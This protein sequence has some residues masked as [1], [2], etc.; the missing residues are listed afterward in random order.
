MSTTC[1]RDPETL[2]LERSRPHVVPAARV[3]RPS[4][5]GMAVIA[6]ALAISVSPAGADN[7]MYRGGSGLSGAYSE[8]I[9]LPLALDWRYTTAFAP[10][11]TSSP[12][13]VGKTVY[14]AGG[15][16]VY[17][18]SSDSGAL[19]WQFPVDQPLSTLIAS[20]PAV[21]DNVVYCGALDGKLY[22]LNAD[23]GK[24][25]WAFDTRS[26]IGSSPTVQDGVIYFGSGD[27]RVWAIDAKTGESSAGPWK[28]G[29]KTSDEITGAPAIANGFVYA[30]SLD[31]VIHAIGS[32]TG[33][34]RWSQRLPGSVLNKS[35]VAFGDY[36]YV[37]DGPN[38]HCIAGRTGVTKWVQLLNSDIAVTPAV[39]DEGLFLVTNDNHV[40]SFDSRTG[41]PRWKTEP[42][43]DF[44]AV[45][46]PMVSGTTLVVG[47]TEGGVYAIDTTSGAIKWTYHLMPASNNTE[48]IGEASNIAAAPVISDGTVYVISN[49]GLA[50]F[51]SD[52]V[53]TLGPLITDTE[54]DMGIV[55]NGA[56][57]IHME[58]KVTD[59]GS[60]V[61]PDSV[62]ILLDGVGVPKRPE[63]RDNEDKP[64][65]KYDVREGIVEYDTPAPTGASTVVP[66]ADGRHT[67]TITASDWMG[68]TASKSWSFTVDNTIARRYIRKRDVRA[69]QSRGSGQ[70]GPGGYPG[71][72]GRGSGSGGPGGGRGRGGGSGG[73]GA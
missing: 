12:A 27:G 71:G 56:P 13:V 25:M 8:K 64:G 43:L 31:Q 34:E 42:K 4:L 58:G 60:G 66:L 61:N 19:K 57:P 11:N 49:D 65:Y 40:R 44:D 21:V 23:S 37:A 38:I 35:P 59:E 70:G 30:L 54:P 50:A 20:S 28:G 39:S 69:S 6:L 51:R 36:V 14:F 73:G 45:A 22:A 47:T 7:T 17:A 9:T 62:R 55:I 63:G 5:P 46:P 24:Q 3:A 15:N 72:S 52:A 48:S 33:K 32:A 16:R 1:A 53:D 2:R 18:V 41:R 67:I 68:N 10:Y 29:V 26:T